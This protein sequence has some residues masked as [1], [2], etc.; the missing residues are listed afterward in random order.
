MPAGDPPRSIDTD[1]QKRRGWQGDHCPHHVR[2]LTDGG[3]YAVTWVRYLGDAKGSRCWTPTRTVAVSGLLALPLSCR[4]P[5]EMGLPKTGRSR[6]AEPGRQSPVGRGQHRQPGQ[7]SAAYW[8]AFTGTPVSENPRTQ[9]VRP[10][11][12]RPHGLSAV[13][14]AQSRC[15]ARGRGATTACRYQAW[16]LPTSSSS[17][18]VGR[19][20]VRFSRRQSL[21]SA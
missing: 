12:S 14:D 17:S 16:P 9:R 7:Q 20:P 8:S 3:G 5:G 4:H 1:A 10:A 6:R 11:A 2:W 18:T 13:P 15:A 21:G 19:T